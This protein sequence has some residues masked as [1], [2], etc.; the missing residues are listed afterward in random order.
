MTD[1]EIAKLVLR[2]EEYLEAAYE[3]FLLEQLTFEQIF[4]GLVDFDSKDK[5]DCDP[6]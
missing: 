4:D 3:K 1:L 6:L 5:D 2:A